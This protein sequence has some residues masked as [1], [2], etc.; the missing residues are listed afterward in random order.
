MAMRKLK[1]E[2]KKP[3]CNLGKNNPALKNNYVKYQE[4]NF[5]HAVRHGYFIFADYQTITSLA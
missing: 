4:K 1:H 2:K 5:G 3:N